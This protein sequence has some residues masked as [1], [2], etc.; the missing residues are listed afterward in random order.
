MAP[1]E[2]EVTT[3]P[4][5]PPLR[6]VCFPLAAG[7][8]ID[9]SGVAIETGTPFHR[10]P[11]TWVVQ[12]F[13]VVPKG[14]A[15]GVG[16][17]PATAT[18]VVEVGEKGA[19]PRRRRQFPGPEDP[20]GFREAVPFGLYREHLPGDESVRGLSSA[21]QVEAC[22]YSM[23]RFDTAAFPGLRLLVGHGKRVAP[24][25]PDEPIELSRVIPDPQLATTTEGIKL[26]A[27]WYPVVLVQGFKRPTSYGL[28]AIGRVTLSEDVLRAWV[29]RCPGVA[30]AAA[31]SVNTGL[32]RLVSP[33]GMFASYTGEKRNHWQS[34]L[35]VRAA[36]GVEAR[37]D[38]EDFAWAVVDLLRSLKEHPGVLRTK[39]PRLARLRWS[40][41]EPFLV[42]GY[43]DKP[44]GREAHMWAGLRCGGQ[45]HFVEAVCG[46]TYAAAGDPFSR[47]LGEV[48]YR[49]VRF[50]FLDRSGWPRKA[51]F[52]YAPLLD[53]GKL[54]VVYDA[55]GKGRG[56][57]ATL[58]RN[59]I[60]YPGDNVHSFT[61]R[62]PAALFTAET[63]VPAP[64]S[65]R[66]RAPVLA[67]AAAAAGRD[68]VAAPPF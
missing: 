1:V 64:A 35:L 61:I 22:Q 16:A 37:V 29:A 55:P 56:N 21:K 44:G 45:Y 5:G 15:G 18:A 10:D 26:L 63:P 14:A 24:V 31:E 30:D 48:R 40:S 49:A 7:G 46:P 23:A 60:D 42:S 28:D 51:G 8:D 19:S 57:A 52:G 68:W 33:L 11:G 38:C 54:E 67:L 4:G 66:A 62:D 36:S 50:F 2:L 12:F 47:P 41:A 6:G 27:M 53:G 59:A 32:K 58:G 34:P 65:A 17:A 13:G 3:P 39:F 25:E 9:V 43:V 20:P